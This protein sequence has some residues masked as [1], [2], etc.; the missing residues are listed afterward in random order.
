MKKFTAD[1]H[2]EALYALARAE[3]DRD[4]KASRLRV[5]ED[6]YHLKI[7]KHL[8]GRLHMAGIASDIKMARIEPWDN[9]LDIDEFRQ[10]ADSVDDILSKDVLSD[11]E[12]RG[13][14]QIRITAQSPHDYVIKAV[15]KLL[16]PLTNSQNDFSGSV[17]LIQPTASGAAN[18]GDTL[19]DLGFHVDGTQHPATPSI[20]VF[21]YISGAKV[22]ATSVFVDLAKVLLDIDEDRRYRI[23]TNLARADAAVFKKKGMVHKGPIFYFSP[24]GKLVCR[25]RFDNVIKVNSKC[26]S[27]FTF[28]RKRANEP[29]YALEFKPRNG[30]IV[31]FD[32]W[33]VLHARDEV[34]GQQIRQH[35]RAWVAN[36]KAT[37]QPKHSLG[38][39]PI[40]AD[41]AARIERANKPLTI[42][43]VVKRT[44]KNARRK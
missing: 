13:I 43:R 1:Q 42:G 16:G 28:L 38:I 4:V 39:R 3:S 17:K 14:S 40:P 35:W 10:D 30:D 21:H 2:L 23:L 7:T 44:R 26:K 15:A 25:V 5:A 19:A 11:L 12:K 27:D 18:S 36:L 34:Y 22:G 37:L 9:E 8:G 41:I 31:L 32:N 6:Y 20:L 24:T 29:Q 33:R